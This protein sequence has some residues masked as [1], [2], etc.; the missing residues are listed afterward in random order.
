MPLP[1]VIIQPL[2][3]H[4]AEIKGLHD[5]DLK[6]GFGEVYLPNALGR[7]YPKAGFEW[8]WQY[9]FPSTRFSV[10]PR[11]NTTRR[12]HIHENGLQRAIKRAAKKAG[13]AKRVNCHALRHSFATHLLESG[14]DIRTVQE[15]LGHVDVSTTMIY[16]HVLN[17]GGKGVLSPLDGLNPIK[18]GMESEG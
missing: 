6:R 4:L 9:V 11:T 10:D 12:H 18:P 7:K 17:R 5:D 15:L 3:E 8:G 14:Y 2:K 13:I 16:T 1:E